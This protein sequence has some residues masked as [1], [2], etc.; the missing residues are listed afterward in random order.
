MGFTPFCWL[1]LLLRLHRV[2]E[3]L[4]RFTHSHPEAQ[5]LGARTL[6]LNGAL[7]AASR[8]AADIL[9]CNGDNIQAVL[10]LVGVH[11]RQGRPAEAM[12][13]LEAAVS[14]NFS[15]REAPLYH[16]T[17]AQ[18]LVANERLEDAKKVRCCGYC[19]AAL[20]TV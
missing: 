13:A 17:H 3:M 5:L 19:C 1:L 8:K 9:R 10:L 2:L 6:F 16:V 18:V 20:P 15:I 4:A 12:A 7:D 11:V 14:A